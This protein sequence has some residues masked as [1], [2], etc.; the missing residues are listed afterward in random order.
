MTDKIAERLYSRGLVT[1][2]KAKIWSDY[3]TAADSLGFPRAY[4]GAMGTHKWVIFETEVSLLLTRL[5][6]QLVPANVYELGWKPKWDSEEKFL[7]QIDDEI[8]DVQELD[9][10]KMSLFDSFVTEQSK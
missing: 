4:I 10:V 5:S 8:K 6:G 3:Y 2:P 7:N 1:E 9:T